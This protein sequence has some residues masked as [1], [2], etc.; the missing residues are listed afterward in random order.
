MIPSNIGS[1]PLSNEEISE[2]TDHAIE[3]TER[4]AKVSKL[5]HGLQAE[6]REHEDVL[7]TARDSIV[8]N[9]TLDLIRI[10]DGKM[11]DIRV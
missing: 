1:D 10:N 5:M 8:Y 2:L 4:L 3:L 11:E 7:C 6:Q 9:L